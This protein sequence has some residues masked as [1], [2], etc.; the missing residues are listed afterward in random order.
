M[1]FLSLQI[2]ELRR[3]AETLLVIDRWT[4]VVPKS[5]WTGM[6]L[7]RH[8]E[9]VQACFVDG[10][11]RRIPTGEFWRVDTD[12]HDRYWLHYAADR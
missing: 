5:G 9:G 4:T 7:R 6:D 8:G 2:A 3:P 12:G 11:S 1:P 10:H